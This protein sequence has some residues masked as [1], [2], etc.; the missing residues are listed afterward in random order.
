MQALRLFLDLVEVALV[1][2]GDLRRDIALGD[3]VH[4]LGGDVQ[5]LD[6]V[7]QRQIEALDHLAEV[8]FVP[9]RVAAHRQLAFQHRLRH[10]HAIVHHPADGVDA[11][12]EVVL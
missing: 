2:V 6:D 9:G 11:G 10:G 7:I 8:A 3:A 4:V 5:R 1:S 12:I